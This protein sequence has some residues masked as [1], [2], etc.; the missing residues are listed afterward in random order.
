MG[1]PIWPNVFCSRGFNIYEGAKPRG[2]RV[3]NG[4]KVDLTVLGS[5]TLRRREGKL[6][7]SAGPNY[8]GNLPL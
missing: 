8:C 4:V 1:E 5:R 7:D 2:H 3:P 6:P